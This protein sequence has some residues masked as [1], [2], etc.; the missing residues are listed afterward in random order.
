[1]KTILVNNMFVGDF[2]LNQG[3][4]PH[5]II[6]L[7]KADNGRFYCYITPLGKVRPNENIDTILFVRST[8]IPNVLEVISKAEHIKKVFNENSDISDIKYGG[9]SIK[10]IHKGNYEDNP[11]YVTYEVEKIS[12]PKKPIYITS[13]KNIDIKEFPNITYTGKTKFNNTSMKTYVEYSSKKDSTYQILKDL[14]YSNNWL[15]SKQTLTYNNTKNT[16]VDV[17]NFFDI[18]HIQ[19]LEVSFSNM[20][21]YYFA[22]YPQI[23]EKFV[24][25]VLKNNKV[26]IDTSRCKVFREKDNIDLRISEDNKYFIILENK[27]HSGINGVKSSL[28]KTNI[29]SQ[30]S[31]YYDIALKEIKDEEKIYC[32][33]LRPDYA[34]IQNLDK[35][36]KGC[37]YKQIKYSEIFEF[38]KNLQ[39]GKV[40]KDKYLNDFV[41]ALYK[42]SQP[43]DNTYKNKIFKIMDKRIKKFV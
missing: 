12:F 19:D 39:C 28:N 3:N 4:L 37:I 2:G 40:I 7:F 32:Y 26:K 13:N 14:I 38:F 36:S 8:N 9:V 30:L 22:Q 21:Y 31:K 6:N 25:K 35:Y 33:I 16:Y 11:I 23:I 10:D 42:H 29:K 20:L 43:V 1:M 34:P 17:E 5:E 27:I 18:L 41:K 24:K 15:S